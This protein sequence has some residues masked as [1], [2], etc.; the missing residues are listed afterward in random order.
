MI[1]LKAKQLFCS[2]GSILYCVHIF[3]FRPV[4]LCQIESDADDDKLTATP[5]V[6]GIRPLSPNLSQKHLFKFISQS[7]NIHTYIATLYAYL[8]DTI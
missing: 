1:S 6:H 7:T 4:E 5:T 3:R 2:L 8:V